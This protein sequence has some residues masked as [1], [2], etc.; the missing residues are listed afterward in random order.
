M[1]YKKTLPIFFLLFA[2]LNS[3][4][5]KDSLKLSI[6]FNNSSQLEAIKLIEDNSNYHFFFIDKWLDNKS[7]INKNFI[8]VSIHQILDTIFYE[9][10]VNYFITDDKKIILTKGNLITNVKENQKSTI[11][12][13]PIFIN[14]QKNNNQIVILGKEESIK[15]SYY[16]L[17]GLVTDFK[18]GKP[19]GGVIV[20]EKDK[21]LFTTTNNKGFYQ[22]KLPLGKNLIE[23]SLT[24]YL[25]EYEEIILY[26]NSSL[27]FKLQEISEQLD[28]I[29]ISTKRRLKLKQPITGVTQIKVQDIKTIPQVLGERDILKVATTLPGI[30]SAGEGAEGLNVRGGKVD[31][32]LFLLDNGTIY[33][34]T[35]FLGLFSAIN[36]FTTSDLK[37]YKGNIPSEFG[38]RLSSVFDMKTKKP[39]TETIKGEGSIG[40]VTSNLSIET[41]I[42]KEKSGLMVGVR[43]TY[44]DWVLKVLDDKKLKNSSAS[45]FDAIAKYNHQINDHNTI[46]ITGYYS[47]DS[48]QIASD[49]INSYGNSLVTLNWEHTFNKKNSSSLFVSNSKYDFNIDYESDG[50]KNFNLK[51][52]I[53]ETNLK[54][55]FK[56][57]HSK[58]HHFNYG[59]ESKLY[60]IS[61]GSIF[62]S[63]K[64]S[65]VTPLII[66]N[67]RALE[68]SL[69]VSDK[70]NVGKKLNLY[71]G[72]RMSQYLALGATNQ[73]IYQ[74]NAPKN[75]STLVETKNYKHNEVHKSYY[76]LSYRLS[77]SY[78]L[79]DNLSLKGSYNRSF[80][81]IHRLSNNTTASP[82]DT[83]RLSDI[84]IKPQEA[85]QFSIGL[86]KNFE[87]SDYEVSFETYYKKFKNIV[88]YK[89]GANLLL[90]EAIETEVIQGPGKSYGAEFLFRKNKGILNGWLSYTYSRSFIKLDSYFSEEIVNAGKYF[91]TNYDKPH[92]LTLVL[93]Y[94]LTKRF[95]LSSNFSFQTGR[96]V[97][98]PAGKYLQGN[99][100][101]QYYSDRNEFRIPDYYRLD[102]GLN[103]EGNH[104]IKKLAH[105]FWNISIY[106]V[107]GRNNPYSVFFEAENGN[108]NGFKSSIFSVP[109]PTITYNF[110]F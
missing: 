55:L 58:Q 97:T 71:L 100:E 42:I 2:F 101:Y 73:R 88:D 72:L 81:Y 41:P 22:L 70:Y 6:K 79:T 84:N 92:D 51:Y 52:S 26:N 62:P 23:T 109:V 94:K 36:P 7:S 49:S 5:Q 17:S 99:S 9:T 85:D 83:W 34:P 24:G 59:L 15:K 67:E 48:F 60:N 38:G 89:I 46:D 50:N 40:P 90:N 54:L 27:N 61:P 66:P 18:N 63:G 39:N 65:D 11:H 105:S 108:V 3:Y 13:S 96:P 14:P 12:E 20:S 77:G 1:L 57:L 75:S 30:K 78:S 35:H 16:T 82:L 45:F 4:A 32:N 25:K 95:S 102:I 91:P 21:N 28:E 29:T 106:N 98:Y 44:S 107:L 93:N 47:E 69:F 74:D 76:N 110:K 43:T 56:Y 8:N 87:N 10:Q 64:D 80:Q 68:N 31:Q 37:I 104:K 53:N 33:N 86:F 103:I 19:I